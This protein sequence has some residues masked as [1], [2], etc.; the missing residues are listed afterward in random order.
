M[1]TLVEDRHYAYSAFLASIQCI[2]LWISV[3]TGL[4]QSPLAADDSCFGHLQV[5]RSLQPYGHLATAVSMARH[6]AVDATPLL[7]LV[8][9]FM[10]GVASA[11]VVEFDDKFFENDGASFDTVLHSCETLFHAI[12]GNFDEEVL[13]S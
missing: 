11:L 9:L 10:I 12:L 6:S 5:A 8:V 7:L 3:R 13:L 4:S 2:A 1:H